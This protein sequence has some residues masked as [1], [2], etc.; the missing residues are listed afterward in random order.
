M[1]DGEF[2]A[3]GEA[4]QRQGVLP[5]DERG[6]QRRLVADVERAGRGGGHRDAEAHAADLD[7]RRLGVQI[8]TRPRSRRS[9]HHPRHAFAVCSI[10]TRVPEAVSVAPSSR[11]PPTPVAPG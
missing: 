8:S 9:W 7:D 4:E 10:D 11:H 1:E 6:V 3:L 2:V 5:H